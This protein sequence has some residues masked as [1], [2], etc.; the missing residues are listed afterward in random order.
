ME[1]NNKFIIPAAIVIAGVIVAIAI[2]YS[3]G[4]S[5]PATQ[6][7]K[8]TDGSLPEVTSSD[9]VL[10]ETS[11][12]VTVVEYGDYQCPF[13]GKFYRETEQVIRDQ[14]VSKGKVRWVYRDFA[15]LGQESTW[16]SEAARC[17][18][19]QGKFWQMHDYLYTHQNGE[20]E[21]AFSKDNLKKFAKA[22]GLDQGSFDSCL[23]TGKYTSA[24]QA[25]TVAGGKAGVNGTPAN[26]INGKLNVGALP[27]SQFV[28]LIE[29][30]LK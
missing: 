27:T 11:A 2:F 22:L 8:N 28:Q 26:F 21:G 5:G 10:G 18:A 17:A 3:V 24:V 4:S 12:P 29:E 7:T 19:D 9:F 23:D 25:E 13:C 20:N 30:A 14:Y 16:A 1:Q 6:P 15:F